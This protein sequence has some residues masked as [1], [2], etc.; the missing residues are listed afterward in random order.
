MANAQSSTTRWM[1]MGVVMLI[2]VAVS[3]CATTASQKYVAFPSEEKTP[4]QQYID[5]GQC[6]EIATMHKGSDADAAVAM[7]A[8]TEPSSA[9]SRTAC[10]PARA[11][12]SDWA[13]A[14][15]SG[16]PSALCRAS[17]RTACATSASF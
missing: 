10:P 8:R 6:E 4:E 14:P 1:C 3:G 15:P 16:S 2:A 17:R 5:R 12:S 11:R 9:P 7:G 13:W